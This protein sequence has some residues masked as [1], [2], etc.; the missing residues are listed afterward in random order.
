MPIEKKKPW[1]PVK[2]FGYGAG[3]PIAW[4]GWLVLLLY[5][6]AMFL[7]GVLFPFIG[8]AIMAILLTGAVLYIA[9]TR[10]DGEWR[11]RDGD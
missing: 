7:S 11:F 2:R 10:S 8:F 6:V 3:L 9:Y 1:F 5:I 4:E